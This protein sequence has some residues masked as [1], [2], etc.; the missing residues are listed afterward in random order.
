M[1]RNKY[2]EIIG[3]ANKPDIGMYIMDIGQVNK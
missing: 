2:E 3:T 1:Q